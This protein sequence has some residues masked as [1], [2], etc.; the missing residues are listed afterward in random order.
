MRIEPSD[1]DTGPFETLYG[2]PRIRFAFEADRKLTADQDHRHTSF[3][4]RLSCQ[5]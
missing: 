4:A 1:K 2:Q 5:C 3:T